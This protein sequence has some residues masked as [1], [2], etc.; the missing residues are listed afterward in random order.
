MGFYKATGIGVVHHG[1][2]DDGLTTQSGLPEFLEYETD[3]EFLLGLEDEMGSFPELPEFGVSLNEG[4]IYRYNDQ[5]FMVRQTHNRTEHDPQSTPALF[6]NWRQEEEEMIWVPGERVYVGSFRFFEG[7]RYRVV[8]THVTQE[9]WTPPN[10]TA[11]WTLDDE[12]NGDSG[13]EWTPNVAYSVG[14]NVTH[15][16]IEYQC[17]QAHTSQIG[18]EPPNVPA[19]WSPT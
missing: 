12:S 5:L 18:W 10:T 9:D 11:L 13:L 7:F 1:F 14:Q 15:N 19:L 17:L 4:E 16:S 6:L 3:V 2:T 8:Q